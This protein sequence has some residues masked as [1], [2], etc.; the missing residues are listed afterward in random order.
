MSADADAS[1]TPEQPSQ[2]QRLAR[3]LGAVSIALG[4]PALVAPKAVD[5]LI[6]IQPTDKIRSLTRGVGFQELAVGAGRLKKPRPVDLQLSRI[7]GDVA[8][9][10]LL[11]R[12]LASKD[13]NRRRVATTIGIVSA[14]TL[15]DVIA[16]MR[17]RRS[18]HLQSPDQPESEQRALKGKTAI[19]VNRPVEEVYRHWRN[20][21]NLPDFMYHLESVEPSGG[22]RSH[23]KAKGPAGTSVEW[24]AEIVEDTP[25]EVIAW[26]SVEGSTVPNSGTVRFSEA[27]RGQG[28]QIVVEIDYTPPGGVLGAAAAKLFGEE[29]EQQ[30][31]DDLR[32]F[33]QVMETGEVVLSDGTPDGTRTQRQL[34]QRPAQPAADGGK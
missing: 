3:G 5:R 15:A 16:G 8:H 34:K 9:L 1:P 30:M 20:L 18:G 6:G 23:W 11:G 22:A 33:K 27:P 7:A 32:R 12:A 24:D 17:L 13:S 31:R 29:P 19:T 25:N 10:S 14:I 28:T 2:G 26:R 21:G 4:L